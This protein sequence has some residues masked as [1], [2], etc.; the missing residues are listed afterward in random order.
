MYYILCKIASFG[1]AKPTK[2]KFASSEFEKE[3]RTG[4]RVLELVHIHKR[5]YKQEKL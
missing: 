3:L 5:P 1:W 4:L 2:Y